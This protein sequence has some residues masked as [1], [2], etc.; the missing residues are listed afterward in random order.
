M[1]LR[2]Y[3]ESAFL[4]EVRAMGPG[5]AE[6]SL[7]REGCGDPGAESPVHRPASGTPS[8]MSVFTGHTPAQ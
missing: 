4:P 2:S 7:E 5:V 6:L 8:T 1:R 3:S